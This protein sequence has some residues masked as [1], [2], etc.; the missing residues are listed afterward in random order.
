MANVLKHR[1]ASA[2]AD[3]GDATQ[4]Q[5]SNWNDGHLFTGGTEGDVLTR[6]DLADYGALWV[7]PLSPLTFTGGG[8]P[9]LATTPTSFVVLLNSASDQVLHG[10]QPASGTF[11]TGARLQFVNVGTGTF[12]L[13]PFSTN[14]P[15]GRFANVSAAVGATRLKGV[16]PGTSV[17]GAAT[18]IWTGTHW[19]MV[20][21]EQGG[22]LTLGFSNANFAGFTAPTIYQQ[23]F[24]LHGRDAHVRLVVDAN[25]GASTQALGITGWPFTFTATALVLMSLRNESGAY[26]N[27]ISLVRSGGLWLDVYRPDLQQW[28]VATHTLHIDITVSIL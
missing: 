24:Y 18:Y 4:V 2:K 7:A 11:K 26:V 3:G 8:W 20:G 21:H 12:T 23:D 10:A 22:A 16:V 17:G 27:L 19:F 15:D 6:G 25:V 9:V 1:F 13:V 28:A 5:P 14:I